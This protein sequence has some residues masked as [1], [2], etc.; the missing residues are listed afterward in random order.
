[1]SEPVMRRT[2][3]SLAFTSMREQTLHFH[4]PLAKALSLC[5]A[6]SLLA[7]PVQAATPTPA[8]AGYAIESP[9][10]EQSLLLDV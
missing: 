6:L 10:A 8:Q 3:S 9:R 5:A 7:L 1:M 4:S 2:P